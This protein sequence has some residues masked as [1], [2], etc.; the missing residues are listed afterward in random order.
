VKRIIKLRDDEIGV[1][2][3]PL[4]EQ[5]W[6]RI[7][8]ERRD[9]ETAADPSSEALE[10]WRV[11]KELD[12]RLAYLRRVCLLCYYCCISGECTEDMDR[13]CPGYHKRKPL[14]IE[15]TLENISSGSSSGGF[16][17][18]R[19]DEKLDLIDKPPEE[20]DLYDLGGSTV[21][22][23]WKYVQQQDA[24]RWGCSMCPKQFLGAEFV[25][26]HVY[27]KHQIGS[28]DT[29]HRQYF[30]S[31]LLDPQRPMP[32][33]QPQYTQP[34]EGGGMQPQGYGVQPRYPFG[35]VPVIPSAPAGTPLDQIPRL[36]FGDAPPFDP[37]MMAVT[38]ADPRKVRSYIDLDAP[39]EGDVPLNYG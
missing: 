36:G 34:Y 9:E 15:D 33:S 21:I 29:L 4:F 32:V 7:L 18:K 24:E 6:S 5:V 26:K 22:N 19:L 3:A 2:S 8:S 27:K 35:P 1:N 30:N 10:L 31:Y 39:V 25:I 11:K 28:D 17:A 37:R 14:S 13:K 38:A 16:W 12:L 20:V 23:I